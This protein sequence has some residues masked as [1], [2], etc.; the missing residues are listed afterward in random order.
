MLT[1]LAG[2]AYASQL[3]TVP[4]LALDADEIVALDSKLPQ[5]ASRRH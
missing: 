4:N 2:M 3:L 1:H 5:R